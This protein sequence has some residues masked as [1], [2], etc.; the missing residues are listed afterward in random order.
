MIFRLTKKLNDGKAEAP[1]VEVNE[2]TLF[3]TIDEELYGDGGPVMLNVGS[4]LVI[5]RLT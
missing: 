4:T 5:E 2:D 1:P 3:D